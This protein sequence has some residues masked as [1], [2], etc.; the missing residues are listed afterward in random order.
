MMLSTVNVTLA[1]IGG[2]CIVIFLLCDV[3]SYLFVIIKVAVVY[4]FSRNVLLFSAH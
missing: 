4:I 3:V 2:T 1:L